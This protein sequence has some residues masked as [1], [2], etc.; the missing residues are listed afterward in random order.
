MAPKRKPLG[1]SWYVSFRRRD[2]GPG[3]DVRTAVGFETE[4]EAKLFAAARLAEGRDVTAGTIN[5]H[6]PKKV[7]SPDQISDWLGDSS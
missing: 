5:P 4:A 1:K 6:R 2:D 3:P 7:V